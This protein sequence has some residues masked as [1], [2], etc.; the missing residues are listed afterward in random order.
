MNC[1][2]NCFVDEEIKAIVSGLSN[3]QGKCD[4]CESIDQNIIDIEELSDYFSPV[5]DLYEVDDTSPENIHQK[6]DADWHIFASD[7]CSKIIL[8]AMFSTSSYKELLTRNVKPN[9][10]DYTDSIDIWNNFTLEIKE[11]NRFLIKNNLFTKEAIVKLLKYHTL[12]LRSSTRFYRGRICDSSTGLLIDELGAP[13]KGK[14]TA[15]RANPQGISYLYLARQEET[16]LYEIRASFL[17]YVSVCEFELNQDVTIVAL[18]EIVNISP[19]LPDLDLKEYVSNKN[20][21]HQFGAALSKPLRRIDSTLEYL[22]TQYLCEYIKSLGY[23]GVEYAS[24]MHN[25]GV[26]YAFFDESKFDK[27]RV[28][29]KEVKSISIET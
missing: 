22:P 7:D 19:F 8:G 23:D 26:N 27:I 16:T 28:F 10:I 11:Q 2:P 24:A 21:L 3:T 6:V 12:T 18:R 9:Y 15:G 1:C 25:G 5:L 29:T 17:D 4:V 14:A 13:P 20:I